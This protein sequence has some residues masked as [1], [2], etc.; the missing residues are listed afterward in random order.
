MKKTMVAVTVLV[1]AIAGTAV[2]ETVMVQSTPMRIAG[3]IGDEINSLV[4]KVNEDFERGYALAKK[5]WPTIIVA[6]EECNLEKVKSL[7]ARG[8]SVNTKDEDGWTAFMW[9]VNKGYINLAKLL[10]DKGA[11]VNA[12]NI[13]G[14]CLRLVRRGCCSHHRGVCGC[15]NGRTLCCDGTLSPSCNCD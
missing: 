13:R 9:A 7:V 4:K 6:A 1:L 5:K 3:S 11:D 10:L 12:K 2:A 14:D 8:A 15:Q